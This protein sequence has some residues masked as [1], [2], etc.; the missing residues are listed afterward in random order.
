MRSL[1]SFDTECFFC[2]VMRSFAFSG[3]GA[4]LAGGGAVLLGVPRDEAVYWAFA[5]AVLLLGIV[6]R[7]RGRRPPSRP[8]G[9]RRPGGP[10]GPV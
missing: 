6:S 5:G 9:A 1:I 3:L 8:P 4:G 10:P 2:R 7:G